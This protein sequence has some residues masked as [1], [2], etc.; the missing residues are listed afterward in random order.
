MKVDDKTLRNLDFIRPQLESISKRGI[1]FIILMLLI[2]CAGIFALYTQVTKGHIVTGMRDNVVW[3]LYIVNFIFFIG[4]S[5]AGALIS[6][7]L[8]LLRVPWRSPII[9]MAEVITV[10]STMIGPAYI[11]LC[12]GRLDRLP[13]LLL[14]G[15]IQ[16]PIIWDVIAITTYLS[17]SIIF[18]YLAMIRDMALLRDN[19]VNKA[20]WR[21]PIYRFLAVRYH[22][23]TKQKELLNL[24]KVAHR[25][26]H[27][28]KQ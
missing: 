12:I 7:I 2:I 6:G 27:V 28:N 5:Y 25:L 14:H 1:A 4:I 24:V 22:D 11:L 8:H 9:R 19:P 16:S 13:N 18:L 26:N 3:G 17:G 15:R 10:I 21:N 23:T 20:K